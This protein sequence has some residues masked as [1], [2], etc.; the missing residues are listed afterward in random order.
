MKERILLVD[1][2]GTLLNWNLPFNEFMTRKGFPQLPDT[3][4]YYSIASR[5]GCSPQQAQEFVN[6]FNSSSHIRTMKPLADSVEY[7]GKLHDL[8][9]RFIAITNIGDAPETYVNRKY[10]LVNVFGDVF[11][12]L[13]CLPSGSDKQTVL[14]RWENT[15]YFWIEDHMRNAEAGYEVGLKPILIEH[16]YNSHYK[17]DLF[18]TV[19]NSTPWKQI[20]GLVCMDYG[21]NPHRHTHQG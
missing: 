13:I 14:K 3:D 10:N 20:F 21:I 16:P 11:D 2:D 9:F 7:V 19:S 8:G 4:W 5:H 18:P 6:E 15:G 12:E 1:V 17:T